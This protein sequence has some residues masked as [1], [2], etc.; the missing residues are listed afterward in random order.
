[1]NGSR[2]YTVANS[3]HVKPSTN[4]TSARLDLE[5]T[6]Q[7]LLKNISINETVVS[8]TSASGDSQDRRDKGTRARIATGMLKQSYMMRANRIEELKGKLHPDVAYLSPRT[9]KTKSTSE[10][11]S[12]SLVPRAGG[13]TVHAGAYTKSPRELLKKQKP[14]KNAKAKYGGSNTATP[15]RTK[16]YLAQALEDAASLLDV[17]DNST[18]TAAGFRDKDL[19]ARKPVPVAVAVHVPLPLPLALA[20]PVPVPVAVA[21][22]VAVARDRACTAH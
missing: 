20:V 17:S 1:M 6:Y 16:S 18:D 8:G 11:R 7:D 4:D 22:A 14:G 9:T 12:S 10:T 13:A 5:E 15:A 19:S 2:A 21:V 3:H